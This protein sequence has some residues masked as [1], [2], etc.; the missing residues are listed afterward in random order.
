MTEE[1]Y[2]ASMILRSNP[3]I[4]R[5]MW[6]TNDGW[7]VLRQTRFNPEDGSTPETKQIRLSPEEQRLLNQIL[8]SPKEIK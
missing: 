5:D 3:G 4:V 2:P 8:N 7:L 1:Q 6:F